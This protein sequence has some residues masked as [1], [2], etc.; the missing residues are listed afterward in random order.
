MLRD[1]F[2]IA[3]PPLLKEEG[4]IRATPRLGQHPLKGRGYVL[5]PV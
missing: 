5:N 1:V 2:W 3:Q 4:K